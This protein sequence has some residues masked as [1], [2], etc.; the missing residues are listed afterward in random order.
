MLNITKA[1]IRN[2]AA[3]EQTYAR[4]IRYYQN[5]AVKNITWS[6][7]NKQYRAFV[8]GQSDYIVTVTQDK[9]DSFTYSCNCP[10]SF[11]YDGPCKH[12]I[13]TLLFIA[14]YENRAK[15]KEDIPPDEKKTYNIID[16]FSRQDEINL[17]G[18]TFHIKV[19]IYVPGIMKADTGKAYLS[20]QVGNNRFYKVQS[21]KKFIMDYYNKE[22][23]ILGK[24]FRYIHGESKFHETSQKIMDFLVEIYEI[25]ELL[26]R[27][28]NANV[29]SKAQLVLTKNLLIKLFSLLGKDTFHLNLYG[30]EYRDVRFY[31]HNPKIEYQIDLSEDTLIMNQLSDDGIIPVTQSGEL[32]FYKHAMYQPNHKFI[33]N[34][35]PFFSSI[36]K[37]KGPLE[38]NGLNKIKF[39]E[40]VLPQIHETMEIQ[41]PEE[42]KN[43]YVDE[44]LRT[45]IYLDKYKSNIRADVKFM[46]GAYKINPL[47]EASHPE[48][49]IVRKPGDEDLVIDYLSSIGFEANRDYFVIKQEAEA[50]DFLVNKMN[51]LIERYDVFYSEAFRTINIR[52]IGNLNTNIKV[53]SDSDLLEMELGFDDI[54][55][56]ELKDLFHSYRLKKKYYR[57]KNGDFINLQTLNMEKA[58]DL[59]EHINVSYKDLKDTN[60]IMLPKN[61]ALYINQV[62]EKNDDIHAEMNEEFH[63][64]VDQIMNPKENHYNIPENINATLRSYQITGYKWLC[65]L[66]DNN[67]GGILADDMGLGKTL[68]SIVYMAA[69]KERPYLIVCPAS[70]VYNWQEEIEKFAPFLN[71]I[72]V[73]G[74]PEERLASIEEAKKP[75]NAIDVVI[76]SYPLIRRDIDAYADIQFHTMFIDEA[77]FIKNANSRNA[78]SVK[79]IRAKHKFALTGT[80]IE[81]SL[82]ELWS[83]FDFIMPFYLFTSSKFQ[84][85]YEKPIIKDGNEEALA[86]LNRHI[87]PFILRRMK[88]EVLSELPDKVETKYMTEM[89]ESQRKVYAAYLANIRNDLFKDGTQGLEKK[90]EILAALTRLRQICCHPSTFIENYK[91]G[92]GKLD[93]LMELLPDIIGAGHRVLIFSQFTTMLHLIEEELRK[94]DFTYFSLEGSTNIETRKDYVNRFNQ[95]ERDIFLISLKAGGTGLNLVGADTVIHF[96]PWWNPAVEEQATDRVYRIGQTNSVQVIK[97]ITQDTI[98]EKIYRLQKKKKNLSDSVIQSKEIFIN[99]LSREELEDI[100]NL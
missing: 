53:K 100:F 30:N 27:A 86:D 65:T 57:L 9:E 89:T 46:Y 55:P 10:A 96:D 2:I 95:G 29:F 64:L 77:Q 97:L 81:N 62:M 76:T 28:N 84:S 79:A 66:A 48:A 41:V 47:H 98:E 18:E 15:A 68:Q 40:Y 39:L 42:I 8:K 50:Y 75:Q 71:T 16:Y 99:H 85:I 51:D 63:Q 1:A 31:N 49:I 90:I 14:D 45:E 69:N 35:V 37:E 21:L 34:F 59:L 23:M 22:D 13:A 12:V 56:N 52:N 20:I 6:Q 67:L 94:S 93:L 92:S 11:K 91:G 25:Q 74:A 83:I 82:S 60:S 80:P 3:D 87:Q 19:C 70:L 33:K 5:N 78:K 58:A 36:S 73:V 61:T 38:F 72:I 43:R 54:P 88:K 17:P 26:G 32:L 24:E 4:G 7:A 44:P